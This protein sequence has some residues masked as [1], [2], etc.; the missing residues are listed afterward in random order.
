MA[1]GPTGFVRSFFF[2]SRSKYFSFLWVFCV[3]FLPSVFITS[4]HN[5]TVNVAPLSP[6]EFEKFVPHLKTT[7]F[8]WFVCVLLFF[9]VVLLIFGYYLPLPIG[10]DVQFLIVLGTMLGWFWCRFWS[11]RSLHCESGRLLHCEHAKVYNVPG[12]ILQVT[13]G[14]LQCMPAVPRVNVVACFA[15]AF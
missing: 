12:C 7:C 5:T 8:F 3:I 13:S 14:T 2:C 15:V 9:F 10:Q 1:L 6:P 4:L 11:G